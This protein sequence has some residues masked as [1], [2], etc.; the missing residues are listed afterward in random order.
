MLPEDMRA[1]FKSE[2]GEADY[3]RYCTEMC[4]PATTTLNDMC[5]DR[6]DI[7]ESV[8]Q[9]KAPGKA[10]QV[11]TAPATVA[12]K[13]SAMTQVGSQLTKAESAA[14]EEALLLLAKQKMQE[15]KLSAEAAG[16]SAYTARM[17]Y[18]RLKRTQ[19]EMAWKA[20]EATM[21]EIKAEAAQTSKKARDIRLAYVNGAQMTAVKKCPRC[22]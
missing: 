19:K 18:E 13:D 2:S 3:T 6:A 7:D 10:N 5:V 1:S 22:R 9:Q 4:G 14:S 17:A 16:R 15:A 11:A 12:H 21:D 20:G 8:E